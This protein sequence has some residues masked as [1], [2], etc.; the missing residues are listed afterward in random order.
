MML[1]DADKFVALRNQETSRFWY[2]SSSGV[3][4][5][6]LLIVG[7]ILWLCRL[8][9]ISSIGSIA[10]FAAISAVAG[11]MGALLSIILRMGNAHLDCSSGKSL[12]Y[13][14]ATSRIFAGSISGIVM[15]LAIKAGVVGAAIFDAPNSLAGQLLLAIMAGASERWMPSIISKFE[16]D[17]RHRQSKQQIE[18]G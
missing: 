4:A 10:F 3:V 17:A 5:A 12:H 14:E 9:I 16:N 8:N 6:I 13:L 2:L 1:A 15:F 7:A 11:A 18:A